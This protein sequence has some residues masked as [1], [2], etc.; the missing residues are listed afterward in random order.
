MKTLTKAEE[1]VMQALWH[2]GGGFVREVLNA[3]PEPRPAY[4][5]VATMLRILDEK[6]FVRHQAVGNSHRFEPAVPRGQYRR[7]LLGRVVKDYFGGSLAEAV[8]AFANPGSL[9]PKEVEALRQMLDSL[10]T[11]PE[12]PADNEPDA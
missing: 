5:T 4:T 3:M 11:E 9:N 8:T 12:T 6:G 7:Q 2:L 10:K 1:E